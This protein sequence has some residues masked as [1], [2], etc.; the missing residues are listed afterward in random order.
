VEFA[1]LEFWLAVGQIVLI[2]I[3]LGG[4]NAVVIALACRNLP[5]RQRRTGIVWGVLGAV[6]LR[7]TLTLFAVALLTIPYLKIAGGL[8]LFWIGVRLVLPDNSGEQEVA[9]SA[10]LW[11]AVKTIIVADFVM[12]LDNV[13]AVAAAAKDEP[14]LIGFGLLVSIPIIVWCS[15]LVLRLMERFP[16][17]ITLGGALLGYIAGDM[18]TRDPAIAAWVAENAAWLTD[19]HAAGIL[20]AAVVAGTGV[21]AAGAARA[22]AQQ[23]AQVIGKDESFAP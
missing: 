23:R 2:D 16:I 12:S 15:Q 8:L 22:R 10:S 19:V 11:A 17:V 18:M 1:S 3:L 14:M 21:A 5:E 6:G 9:A 13:V 20:G 7:T 4:D